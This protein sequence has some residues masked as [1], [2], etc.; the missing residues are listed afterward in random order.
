MDRTASVSQSNIA[1]TQSVDTSTDN[2]KKGQFN[3]SRDALRS[4]SNARGFR[5]DDE[6]KYNKALTVLFQR[7]DATKLTDEAVKA[8]SHLDIHP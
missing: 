7:V 6:K 2:K 5:Q 1:L 3:V 8:C 4:G